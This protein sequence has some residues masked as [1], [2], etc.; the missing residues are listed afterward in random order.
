MR[1]IQIILKEWIAKG[2]P[3]LRAPKR[4]GNHTYNGFQKSPRP[5]LQKPSIVL[6][7]TT[8]KSLRKKSKPQQHKMRKV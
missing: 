7:P 1:H 6:G 2:R 5:S 3:R 8:L 4:K